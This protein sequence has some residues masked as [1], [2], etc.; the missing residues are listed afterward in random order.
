MS[1]SIEIVAPMPVP[2]TSILPFASGWVGEVVFIC[3]I[4]LVG[5]AAF[6]AYR[7]ISRR[8]ASLGKLAEIQRKL[9]K[10]THKHHFWLR[11]TCQ[12]MV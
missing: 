8:R 7:D 2:V 10:F 1:R 3:L 12:Y 5:L 11:K 6:W 4:F 9:S